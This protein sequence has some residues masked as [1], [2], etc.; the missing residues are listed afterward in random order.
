MNAVAL[1]YVDEFN[2]FT[3]WIAVRSHP[4]YGTTP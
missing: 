2:G 4:R 3:K 1:L